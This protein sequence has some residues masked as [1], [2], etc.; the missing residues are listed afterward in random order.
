MVRHVNKAPYLLA[1]VRPRR[2]VNGPNK[3]TPTDV[4]GGLEGVTRSCGKLAIFCCI[5]GAWRRRQL[6]HVLRMLRTLD[7]APRI[8]YL[9]LM[10]DRVYSIPEWAEARW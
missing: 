1:V 4:K 7:R 8:Q 2:T 6:K 5:T 3:S 10:S 9:C